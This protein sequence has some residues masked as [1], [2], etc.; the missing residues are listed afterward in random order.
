MLRI[1]LLL[2]L[3]LS[4]LAF[5]C[6][7]G[8]SGIDDPFGEEYEDGAAGKADGNGSAKLG[9]GLNVLT[10][11]GRP[12]A[13]FKSTA[14]GVVAAALF[15][16][17]RGEPRT[18]GAILVDPSVDKVTRGPF[19]AIEEPGFDENDEPEGSNWDATGSQPIAEATEHGALLKLG[20]I[21]TYLRV[22]GIP[23][24]APWCGSFAT[25]LFHR[26]GI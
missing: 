22:N 23:F 10:A 25:Y 18:L 16:L 24:A 19:A 7:P 21:E 3:S 6:A 12:R 9:V 5:G 11:A 26:A 8:M 17:H 1:R 4:L 14:L 15:E 20:P 2:P 13:V